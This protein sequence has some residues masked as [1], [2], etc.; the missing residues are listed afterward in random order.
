LELNEALQEVIILGRVCS[1]F[2]VAFRNVVVR[3]MMLEQVLMF[4]L[5]IVLD[6]YSG[7]DL[8]NMM[9]KVRKV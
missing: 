8:F 7:G 3:D 5:F 1:P 4:E 2:I 6:Y 9:K